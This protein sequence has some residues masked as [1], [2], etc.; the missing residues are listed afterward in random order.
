MGAAEGVGSVEDEEGNFGF[1]GGLHAEAE[2]ADVGV[3]PGANV[4]DI[5]DEDVEVF[6]MFFFGFLDLTVEA[7]DGDA[8]FGIGFVGDFCASIG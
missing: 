8:S 3:E 4:L 2:R 1:S 5:V 7:E 6:E